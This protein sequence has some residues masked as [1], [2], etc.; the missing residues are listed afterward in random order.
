MDQAKAAIKILQCKTEHWLHLSDN[1]GQ[2]LLSLQPNSVDANCPQG[3]G[4]QEGYLTP[5]S[6]Q[7]GR[8]VKARERERER[9]RFA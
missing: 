4:R 1:D 7:T 5:V 6:L 3:S 8:T 9:G 2:E